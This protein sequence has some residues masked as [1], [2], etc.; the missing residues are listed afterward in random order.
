MAK[1][2]VEVPTV[3]NPNDETSENGTQTVENPQNEQVEEADNRS[4]LENGETEGINQESVVEQPSKEEIPINVLE[5]LKVFND[6]EE[7]Y[8]NAT[9]RVFTPDAKLSLRGNAILY[10]NPFYNSKS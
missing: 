6:Y 7:L 10:K 8:V 5:I 4:E 2:K 1:K 9:G 3:E